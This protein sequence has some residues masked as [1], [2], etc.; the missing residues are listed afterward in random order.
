MRGQQPS[1]VRAVLLLVDRLQSLRVRL[2][3][4]TICAGRLASPKLPRLLPA[5]WRLDGAL[6]RSLG[7]APR[8]YGDIGL[9]SARLKGLRLTRIPV[10]DT[11]LH[12]NGHGRQ[13]L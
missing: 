3:K 5:M 4:V 2:C 7:Y 13:G 8:W 12:Q 1:S 6:I 10:G 11:L 9:K